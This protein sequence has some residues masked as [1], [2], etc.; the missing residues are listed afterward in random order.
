[1]L[2]EQAQDALAPLGRIVIAASGRQSRPDVSALL[3]R[4]ATC[5]TLN[6]SVVF[7]RRPERICAAWEQLI[8]LYSQ[9]LLRPRIGQQFALAQAAYTH[10][11]L[12]SR[13]STDK[14]LL[15]PQ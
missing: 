13:A 1:V 15:H 14:I 9:G 12:E 11:V 10:R 2:F 3:A 4:S 5:A 8:A 7:A 6:L